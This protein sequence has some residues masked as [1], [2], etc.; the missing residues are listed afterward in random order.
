[1]PL[2][3]LALVLLLAGPARAAAAAGASQYADKMPA[4]RYAVALR[5][6]LCAVCARAIAAE[7]AKLPELEKA[8]VDFDGESAVI[9]VRLNRTLRTAAL[10][11]AL[12]RAEKTANL[13]ARFE[14][15][16]IRYLP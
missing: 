11:K 16:D 12:R 13:G 15:S 9:E 3:L 5:G 1:M 6:M 14:L 8:A 7:W 2:R 4:G 10:R